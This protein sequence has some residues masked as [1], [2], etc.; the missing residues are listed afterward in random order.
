MREL[1]RFSLLVQ[2]DDAYH[3]R[4]MKMLDFAASKADFS[5]FQ[6]PEESRRRKATPSPAPC[7]ISTR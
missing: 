4:R 1:T 5:Q 3:H 7:T 2:V 6:L